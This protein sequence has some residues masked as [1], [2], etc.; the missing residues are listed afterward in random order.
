MRQAMIRSMTEAEQR[1]IAET[2]R[3]ELLGLDEDELLDLH[4]RIQRAR[5][6]YTKLYRRRAAERVEGAGGRGKGFPQNQR[7]RDKA[8]VF[9]DALAR[10]SRQVAVVAKA[11]AAELRAE[12]IAAA[13]NDASHPAASPAREPA[14]KGGRARAHSKTTGGVK[15]DASSTAAGARRQAKKDSR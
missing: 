13:R 1:L 12:R 15:K 11:A 6:K 2:E 14:A 10:L 4:G 8:E 7:D 5:N 3:G 9:E